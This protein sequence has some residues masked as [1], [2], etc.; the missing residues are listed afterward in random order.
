MQRYLQEVAQVQ[1]LR[2][3]NS[4]P[5]LVDIHMAEPSPLQRLLA[6]HGFGQDRA[7]GDS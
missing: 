1:T 7:L 2:G 5:V 3:T 4:R 6:S